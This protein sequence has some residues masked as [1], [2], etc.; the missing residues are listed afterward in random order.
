MHFFCS[1]FACAWG[2]GIPL[3]HF[4]QKKT[5]KKEKRKK[6]KKNVIRPMILGGASELNRL[7]PFKPT[8][9]YAYEGI[10]FEVLPV[11]IPTPPWNRINESMNP[12]L[13]P[14]NLIH[15]PHFFCKAAM[16]RHAIASNG[17][18]FSPQNDYIASIILFST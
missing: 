16:W 15:T 1:N 7:N 17:M 18:L 2:Q 12:S 3:P 8:Y 4:K 5:K 10:I 13:L 6:Q 9:F 14:T 11:T